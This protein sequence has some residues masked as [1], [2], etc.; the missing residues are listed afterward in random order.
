MRG[1]PTTT[2]QATLVRAWLPTHCLQLNMRFFLDVFRVAALFC[3]PLLLRF[4]VFSADDLTHYVGMLLAHN[5]P[6]SKI[7][8]ELE[9]FLDE[10]QSDVFLQWF[11][12]I[13]YAVV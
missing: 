4:D 9:A 1:F 7:E 6:R 11:G 5:R 8:K 3:L 12:R 2:T 13:G 10:R